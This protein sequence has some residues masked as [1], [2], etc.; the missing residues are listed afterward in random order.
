MFPARQDAGDSAGS[1]PRVQLEPHLKKKA[2]QSQGLV[3][4]S[5][6]SGATGCAGIICQLYMQPHSSRALPSL[7]T[8]SSGWS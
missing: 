6:S 3:R 1:A 2:S 8:D 7:G 5:K 4:K